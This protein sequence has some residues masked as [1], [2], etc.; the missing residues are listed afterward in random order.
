LEVRLERLFENAGSASEEHPQRL[1]PSC[2]DGSY[3]TAE[4]VPLSKTGFRQPGISTTGDS[5]QPTLGAKS[6]PKMGHPRRWSLLRA[7]LDFPST[8]ILENGEGETCQVL[9]K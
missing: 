7:G 8:S 2:K 1:K 3:G 6:A 5:L 4:A 9:E